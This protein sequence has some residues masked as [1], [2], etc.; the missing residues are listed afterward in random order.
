MPAFLAVTRT[1]YGAELESLDFGKHAEAARQSINHWVETQTEGKIK[2]LILAA[3]SLREARLVLTNAVYFKGDWTDPFKRTQ[4]KDDDFHI[5]PEQKK[6]TPLMHTQHRFRYLATDG[7]QILELPYGDGS[8]SLIALLPE[9]QDGLADLEARLTF[10]N[11]QNWT[12]RL[13]Q[14]P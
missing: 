6:K 13:R 5:S 3:D 12:A 1:D 7:V 2:E 4:T 11:W 9:K 8:L 14:R 10:A